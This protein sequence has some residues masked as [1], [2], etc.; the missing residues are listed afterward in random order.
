MKLYDLIKR[1]TLKAQ[2]ENGD[3]VS[4]ST[5][6]YCVDLFGVIGASRNNSNQIVDLFYKAYKENPKLAL[7][8]LMYSRDIRDG[9]GERSTFRKIFFSL[10]KELPNIANQLVPFIGHI[11][12]YDDLF[13]GLHTESEKVIVE[14]ISNVLQQDMKS[15]EKGE[16]VSLLAKWMPSVNTSNK[17][18]VIMAKYLARKLGLNEQKYRKMLSNLRRGRI[19]ENNLREKEYSFDYQA[20]PSVA[21]HKYKEAFLRNDTERYVKYLNDVSNGNKKINTGA[22]YLYD[23]LREAYED[24]QVKELSKEQQ[25]AMQIKWDNFSRSREI[26]NTIVVRDGSYSMTCNKGLPMLIA[27]SL[28]IYFAEL[29][30]GDFKNKF[31]TFSSDPKLVE[32]KSKDLYGKLKELE[33]Y[34]DPSNTNISKVYDLL[35][36]VYKSDIDKEDLIKRI[37]IISDME[38]DVGVE[39]ISTFETFKNKFDKLNIDMPEVIY[40][41]VNA[42]NIHFV[43]DIHQK[44]IKYISGASSKI[45]DSLINNNNLDN[46]TFIQECVS[47][48]TF[49][50]DFIIDNE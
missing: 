40:W 49:I 38:F 3:T 48:Y 2:T 6:N 5:L 15:L 33:K 30:T 12:R 43:S 13:V 29:L 27:N 50:D 7:K 19:I 4:S 23:I 20:V 28:S 9:L 24:Y 10:C 35:L 26:G 8:I 46:L 14:Y 34:S 32:F 25:L 18:T 17:E 22:L 47:K 39:G 44:N 41:N 1:V 45:I 36:E 37:V 11:G 16:D 42:R 31:I 21:L